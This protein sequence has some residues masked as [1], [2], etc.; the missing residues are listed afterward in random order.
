MGI[1]GIGGALPVKTT[2]LGLAPDV[3][4]LAPCLMLDDDLFPLTLLRRDCVDLGELISPLLGVPSS[5]PL[6][7]SNSLN[8]L[9]FTSPP[10]FIKLAGEFLAV[11]C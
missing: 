4:G 10:P 11:D 9:W 2:V 5:S 1:L 8:K 3:N 6:R 7:F